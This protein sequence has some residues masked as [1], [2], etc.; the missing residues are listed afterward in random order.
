MSLENFKAFVREKPKLNEAVTN[1]EKTWQ[2]FYEMYEL[3][4]PDSNVWDR[5]LG[6]KVGAAALGAFSLG[7]IFSMF[8]NI[9]M[10]DLQRGIGSLQKGIGYL[11]SLTSDRKEEDKKPSYEPR[12]MHKHFDD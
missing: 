10:D 1:K 8:K 3:Y 11:Q 9:R 5:Y 7:E 4:G 12:P 6:V 2:E